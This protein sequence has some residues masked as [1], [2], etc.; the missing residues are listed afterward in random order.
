MRANSEVSKQM[1]GSIAKACQSPAP[2]RK[3]W[4]GTTKDVSRSPSLLETFCKKAERRM[5]SQFHPS[6]RLNL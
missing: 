5:F 2:S 1:Q 4:M 6:T 3:A